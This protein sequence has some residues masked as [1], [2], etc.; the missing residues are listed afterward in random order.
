MR[1]PFLNFPEDDFL[2]NALPNVV[3]PWDDF[4]ER[5]RLFAYF[6]A[7]INKLLVHMLLRLS[8]IQLNT[9]GS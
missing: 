2:R 1:V 9:T 8:T 5:V 6:L 3:L 7:I 4:C